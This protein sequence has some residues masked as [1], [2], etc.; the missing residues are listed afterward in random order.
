M[1]FSPAKVVSNLLAEFGVPGDNDAP[2][3]EKKIAGR[4]AAIPRDG[5]AASIDAETDETL[6]TYLSTDD[7]SDWEHCDDE[8]KENS[9]TTHENVN[10]FDTNIPAGATSMTQPLDVFLR[11]DEKCYEKGQVVC[12]GK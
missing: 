6:G 5:A 4:F 9:S 7:E 10:H 11:P 8:D 2:T 12:H 3:R 1:S